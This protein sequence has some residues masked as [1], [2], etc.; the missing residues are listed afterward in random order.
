MDEVGITFLFF[1]RPTGFPPW[2]F[3]TMVLISLSIAV[4]FDDGGD[5]KMPSSVRA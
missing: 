4:D 1:I 3:A 2:A 5:K